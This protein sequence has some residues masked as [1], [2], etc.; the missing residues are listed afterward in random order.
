[1]KNFL[2]A[3]A[4]CLLLSLL[5]CQDTKDAKE[6]PFDNEFYKNVGKEIPF[7]VGMRWL[8]EYRKQHNIQGRADA[9]YSVSALQLNLLLLSEPTLTGVVFHYGLD[10]NGVKHIIVIPIGASM[11]MWSSSLTR[12]IVDAN[13]GNPISQEVAQ[14][15]T[16]N[17]VNAN[18]NEIRYHFFGKNIFDQI[19]ALLFFKELDIEPAINDLDQSEQMLLIVW[20]TVLGDVLGRTKSQQGVVYDASNP[21]P[22]TCAVQ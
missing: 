7:E 2:I 9:L 10:E 17:Y 16:A 20:K 21:C 12:V 3:L 14:T 1:M 22:P 8:D 5:G 18:P 13:T 11:T 4:G 19:T 15:W 6:T